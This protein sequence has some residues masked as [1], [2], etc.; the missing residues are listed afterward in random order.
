MK[1]KRSHDGHRQRL[2][3]RFLNSSLDSFAP[4]NILELLLFYSIPRQDTNEI[5][6]DLIEHFGSLKRVFDADFSELIKVNGIKENSATLIKMLPQLARIYFT[7]EP[8][9]K[10][11]FDD[12]HKIG[13][14]LVGKYIGEKKEVVYSLLL[15]NSFH[16]I[17]AVKMAEGNV[18]AVAFNSST[19]I[20][21]AIKNDAAF[22][23]IAH[24]H[25]NGI[26]C[27]SMDDIDATSMLASSLKTVNVE[28]LEH[29][30]I[31]GD[32]YL[33]IA[34][35]SS[36]LPKHLFTPKLKY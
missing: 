15:D 8:D 34:K 33:P 32:N 14:Y 10:A 19:V 35:E 25:P 21:Q 1:E 2:K 24:N 17:K 16:L 28:L 13:K 31:V 18:S 23:V 20:E 3:E 4:H 5:A 9:K 26:L 6:H 29:F 36:A 12:A 30:L 11:L 22:V 27:P 7:E